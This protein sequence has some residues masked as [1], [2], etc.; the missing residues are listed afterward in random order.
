MR[1]LPSE[2]LRLEKIF[3]QMIAKHLS[4]EESNKQ[5]KLTVRKF[6][7]GLKSSEH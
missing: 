1:T 5:M 7:F 2:N 3:H 6:D 4:R